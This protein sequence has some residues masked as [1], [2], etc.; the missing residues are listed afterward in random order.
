VGHAPWEEWEPSTSER[1]YWYRYEQ[2]PRLPSGEIDPLALVTVCDSMP[3]AVAERVGKQERMW[4][5]PSADLTVHV[6][7]EARGEWLLAHNWARHA[8]E[9]WASADMA[10]WDAES[11][12]LVAYGTQ[13][14]LFTFFDEF[15]PGG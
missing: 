5:A 3:G 6:L 4:F 12:R 15:P 11:R 7:G 10:L 13:M 2:T 8:G 1:V 14:M 9:G